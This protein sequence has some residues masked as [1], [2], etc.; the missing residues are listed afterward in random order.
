MW[1]QE[2][3]RVTGIMAARDLKSH[4]HTIV[5]VAIIYVTSI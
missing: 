5:S 1:P 2:A 3:A 4:G